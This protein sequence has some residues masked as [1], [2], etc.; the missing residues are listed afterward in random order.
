MHNLRYGTQTK[1]EFIS[2]MI[3][4]NGKSILVLPITYIQSSN[5]NKI[6]FYCIIYSCITL[7]NL[8]YL[9]LSQFL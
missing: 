2:R 8:S 1:S 4:L 7:M 9:S 5:N 6:F 3:E